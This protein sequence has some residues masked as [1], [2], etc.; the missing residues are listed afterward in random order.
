MKK[1]SICVSILL[2]LL[3]VCV[4]VNAGKVYVKSKGQPL[5]IKLTDHLHHPYFWWPSTLLSYR[6]QFNEQVKPDELRLTCNGTEIPFQLSEAAG[7]NGYVKTAVLNFISDLPS[8]V[9]YTFE[10]SNANQQDRKTGKAY[11]SEVIQDAVIVLSSDKLSVCIPRSGNYPDKVPGPVIR[12]SRNGKDWFGQA[13]MEV[14]KHKIQ[15]VE[16]ARL[17]AGPLFIN[18]R[19]RYTFDNGGVYESTVKLIKGY[20]F[21]EFGENITGLKYQDQVFFNFEWTNFA[22]THRQAPNHPYSRPFIKTSDQSGI[23]RF[24]WETIDQNKITGHHGVAVNEN[25]EGMIPFQL[26]TFDP[27]P[28]DQR[29]SSAAFWDERTRQAAGIFIDK[30]ELWEDKTYA[31]WHSSDVMHV[32]YY[33]KNQLLSWKFPLQEGSRSCGIACYD[34]FLDA[35]VMDRMEEEA[36]VYTEMTGNVVLPMVGAPA[37]H[38]YSYATYL[39][40][41]YGTIHLNK[42]KEWTLTYDK[43]AKMPPYVFKGNRVKGIADFEKR[44]SYSDFIYGL[45]TSGPRQN[46]GLGPVPARKFYD[47]W[48]ENYSKLHSEF[49]SDQ[50]ERLTAL[51]LLAAYV[52]A[53]EDLMPMKRMLSGHPNFIADIKSVPALVAFLFPEHPDAE[54][55]LDMF[56]RYVHFNTLYHTRPDVEAWDAQGGRWTENLGTY[57]WGFLNV[58]LRTSTMNEQFGVANNKN[59]VAYEN[60]ARIGRWME[61]AL[62]APFEGEDLEFYRNLNGHLEAHHWGIVTPDK[63]PQRLHPPQGA[64]SARRMAPR[65]LWLLGNNLFRYDPLLA[66]NLMWIAKPDNPEQE[67]LKNEKW[68]HI[69][70]EENYNT[71]TKPEFKSTKFTGYGMILRAGVDTP[72][73]L[74]VHLQQIDNGPNYR[75]GEAGKGGCGV[76]YYYAAGKSYSHNGR[77]DVG[78]RRTQDTDFNSNFGVFKN[79]AFRSIG[80]N[81]LERPWYDLGTGK[82]AEVISDSTNKE[83]WPDYLSRSVMLVGDDYFITYDDLYN[84]LISGRFSWFTHPNDELPFIYLIR[85]NVDNGWVATR[86]SEITTSESKG[87]WF[88]GGGDFICLISHKKGISVTPKDY[89]AIVKTPDG[90]TDYVFRTDKPTVCRE[91]DRLFNGTA[92]FIR[93]VG[94]SNELA[95][96]HGQEIGCKHF[97]LRVSHTDVGVSAKFEQPYEVTGQYSTLKEATLDLNIDVSAKKLVVYID[98]KPQKTVQN[99]STVTVQLPAGKHTWQLSAGLPQPIAPQILYTDN[100]LKGTTI[101]F[102]D[103]PGA[104]SY[105][106]EYSRDGGNN[107]TMAG[108]TGKTNFAWNSVSEKAKVHV[109]VIAV[110]KRFESQASAH[111]PVYLYDVRPDCPDGLKLKNNAGHISLE[112]GQ[113]L[114]VK[115]YKLYRRKQGETSYVKIYQGEARNFYDSQAIGYNIA[116]GSIPVNPVIYEYAV[117][118]ENK[119]GESRMSFPVSTDPYN[120]LNWDPKPNE[121]FRRTRYLIEGEMPLNEIY[122]PD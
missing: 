30:P 82:F 5:V 70:P 62:S 88:D 75:W 92:G 9:S 54:L 118:S 113:V 44:F 47:E 86:K 6:V 29:L 28:A 66:E 63:A 99:S 98:G 3:T 34:H 53:D 43:S 73:E 4:T 48:V 65:S 78:D 41:R 67:D 90:K 57:V 79:G 20:D 19:I 39:Q 115:T 33:Y 71:G 107:W 18:Y 61:G 108:T 23:N 68:S 85:P 16:T 26:G 77:E 112:W 95:L 89:G 55:W 17:E 25:A 74:S 40:S 7:E 102:T 72:G 38:P 56:E 1:V 116:M 111:Y 81:V 91:D 121:K 105:R 69:Y 100:Q 52:C 60:M 35:E 101:Y 15:H 87:V 8:G 80:S 76:I 13:N 103:A 27:W 120:W 24:E 21:V 50:W 2:L 122:Y 31:I 114:G 36:K 97:S 45:A 46:N 58:T 96:F 94:N 59:R 117:C 119:I 42:V 64:H 106:I 11:V 51:M 83:V 22:P 110:N 109:R 104:T 10:L 14:G 12:I 84:D 32:K 93:Q 49:T 37:I